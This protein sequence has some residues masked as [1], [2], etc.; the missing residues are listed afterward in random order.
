MCNFS[1]NIPD[2]HFLHNKPFD[3]LKILVFDFTL[4]L[5]SFKLP[6]IYIYIKKRKEN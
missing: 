4:S 5:L 3:H 6:N 1:K 2:K